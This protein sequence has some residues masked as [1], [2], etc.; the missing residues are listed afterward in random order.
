VLVCPAISVAQPN[1]F[2]LRSFDFEMITWPEV[3][4]AGQ[5]YP[6]Q[7]DPETGLDSNAR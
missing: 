1:P 7:D 6:T 3:K 4:K 5:S 2:A